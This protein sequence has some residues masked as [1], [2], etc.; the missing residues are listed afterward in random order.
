MRVDRCIQVRREERLEV[1]ASWHRLNQCHNSSEEM[2]PT[3]LPMERTLSP[4]RPAGPASPKVRQRHQKKRLC[5]YGSQSLNFPDKKMGSLTSSGRTSRCFHRKH[6]LWNLCLT[7]LLLFG[8]GPHGNI[9]WPWGRCLHCHW[10]GIGIAAWH[11]QDP[12][13][14]ANHWMLAF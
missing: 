14:P 7:Q 6:H 8:F 3:A 4:Y 10:Q 1:A 13:S 12:I 11:Q 2:A 9:H 5:L